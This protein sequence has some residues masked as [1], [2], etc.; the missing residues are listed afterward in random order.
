LE[1]TKLIPSIMSGYTPPLVGA[2]NRDSV[3][4]DFDYTLVTT[5]LLKG[6]RTGKPQLDKIMALKINDFNLWDHKNFNM[7]SPHRY[8]TRK[9]GK[10]SII[11]PQPC[12][13]DLT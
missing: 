12:T 3:P 7:F 10:K 9:K 5:Y 8:L 1:N 6:M 11:I 13:M 4:R 2:V